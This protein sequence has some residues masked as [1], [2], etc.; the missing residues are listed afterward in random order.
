LR[1]RQVRRY[2]EFVPPHPRMR[3]LLDEVGGPLLGLPWLPPSLPWWPLEGRFAEAARSA[4][5]GGL[6]KILF[7][8]PCGPPCGRV[9]AQLRV[10]AT[11]VRRGP[12]SRPELRLPRASSRR[13]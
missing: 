2:E 10:R 9:A 11:R 8:L 3:A 5:V 1:A 12:P 7:T 6:S 4:P 13:A